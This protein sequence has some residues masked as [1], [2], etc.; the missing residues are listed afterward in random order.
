MVAG[1]RP[2][3]LCGQRPNWGS[4]I[5]PGSRSAANRSCRARE[6][7][8]PW[9]GGPSEITWWVLRTWL[10]A[11]LRRARAAVGILTF[12]VDRRRPRPGRRAAAR[13]PARRV[14]VRRATVLRRARPGGHGA[15]PR[16]D[17]P[18]RRA[19]RAA[20]RA[21]PGAGRLRRLL[22]RGSG[23][24][25]SGRR[26]ATACCCCRSARSS[27]SLVVVAVVGRAWPGCCSRSTA[28]ALPGGEAVT[29]LDWRHGSRSGPGS[30]SASCCLL[31]A[32]LPAPW[33]RRRPAQR[34]PARCSS[35][36]GAELLRAPGVAQL[37]ESR[38][39][40]VDAADAE[41][42]RIERDLHD[43]AQ[44]QLVSL[45][46]NLGMAKAKLDCR[47]RGRPRAGRPRR[48]RRPRTRSPSCATWSAACTRRCS[49]TAAST[50]RC[51]RSPPARRCRS[52]LDVDVPRRPS[53]T[54]EAV[55]YFVVCEALTNVA[56]H[57]GA[58]RA[59][60]VRRARPATGC[61]SRDHRR[62]PR[63]RHRARGHR[64]GRPARPGARRSTARFRLHS[65]PPAARPITVEL[66]CES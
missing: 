54:V 32:A 55:A 37:T 2:A 51:P 12:T 66:P 58:R 60:V 44:Q 15:G 7:L 19:A 45:A 33:P 27:A 52:R 6:S 36:S 10:S 24:R 31:L 18:R 42:R 13:F 23:R 49:P 63:R 35:P 61:W 57:A 65:P 59:A 53:P 34:W 17:V 64:P 26:P 22:A 16:R 39:R 9:T 38:A 56:K 30:R 1:E 14:R 40:V 46:M 62:R 48:T 47:P 28:C 20:A 21:A 8:A 11:G 4:G 41:R 25:S 43:G 5:T 3:R 50:R 29:W